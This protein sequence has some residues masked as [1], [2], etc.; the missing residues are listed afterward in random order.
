[1]K[2]SKEKLKLLS[3]DQLVKLLPPSTHD[4]GIKGSYKLMVT[5]D[6]LDDNIYNC[7]YFSAYMKRI[8]GE[9]PTTSGTTIKTALIRMLEW[10]YKYR[11]IALNEDKLSKYIVK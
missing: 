7:H 10:F 8:N 9:V 1:M 6:T 5:I 11:L 3:V 2:L 4:G